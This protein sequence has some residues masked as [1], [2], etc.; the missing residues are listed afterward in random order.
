VMRVLSFST[1]LHVTSSVYSECCLIVV[2]VTIRQQYNVTANTVTAL[3]HVQYS[4]LYIPLVTLYSNVSYCSVNY[5][6]S[7]NVITGILQTITCL[8]VSNF[9]TY[10][11]SLLMEHGASAADHLSQYSSVLCCLRFG[12]FPPTSC[13]I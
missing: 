2:V 3:N 10:A 6:N 12:G 7:N 13:T 1:T 9:L 11:L 4:L 5:V 8:I